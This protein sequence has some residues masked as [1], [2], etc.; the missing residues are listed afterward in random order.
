M[1]KAGRN[2]WV[3][4]YKIEAHE[5]E[6][7]LDAPK[8]LWGTRDRVAYAEIENGTKRI[9]QS[10]YLVRVDKLKIQK[11]ERNKWRALFSFNGD[12]YDLPVTDPHADR[13]LQNPQ[14]QGILCVS[15]GEKFRP[16]GSEEDY[17]YK[18]VAA[19]I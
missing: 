16:Q 11:N 18:I 15:L 10:L 7:Y 14:H 8:T 13:H 9:T 12:F 2:T 5:V 17:C 6:G 19:I 1:N 3:Q 4:R